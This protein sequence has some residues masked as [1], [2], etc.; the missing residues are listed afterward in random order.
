MND[1]SQSE[2][3]KQKFDH[4]TSVENDFLLHLEHNRIPQ[5]GL[6][7]LNELALPTSRLPSSPEPSPQG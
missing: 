5:H 4:I 7:K 1:H 2:F 3:L 6:Q